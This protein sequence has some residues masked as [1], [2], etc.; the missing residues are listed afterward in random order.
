MTLKE[1]AQALADL[2]GLRLPVPFKKQAHTMAG[3]QVPISWYW[4]DPFGSEQ[5]QGSTR[6][7][8]SWS[9]YGCLPGNV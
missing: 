1:M 5:K 6:E 7:R 2:F 9:Q 3:Y 4:F 8:L